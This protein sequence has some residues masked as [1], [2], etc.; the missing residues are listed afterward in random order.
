MSIYGYRAFDPPPP[1][2]WG[3]RSKKKT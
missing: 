2:P 1:E 3:K